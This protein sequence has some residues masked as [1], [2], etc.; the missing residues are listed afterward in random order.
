MPSPF[1]EATARRRAP[2]LHHVELP[3]YGDD[4]PLKL[5]LRIVRPSEDVEALS[6]ARAFAKGKG[7]EDP[8]EDEPIY[9]KALMAARLRRACVKPGSDPK[10]PT[11]LFDSEE[12][13]M[14]S[15]HLG[16]DRVAY[17]YELYE[18]WRDE[19]SPLEKVIDAAKA[20]KLAEEVWGSRTPAPFVRLRPGLRWICARTWAGMVVM[21]ARMKSPNGGISASTETRSTEPSGSD[22]LASSS[23]EP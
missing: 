11:P 15:D 22:I 10:A 3:M 4:E 18:I 20:M 1:A 8:T 19:V 17:L 21:Q 13:I 2:G 14:S 9:S 16:D 5:C 7:I 12:E 23:E 6:W